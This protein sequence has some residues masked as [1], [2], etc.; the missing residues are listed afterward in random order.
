MASLPNQ[1]LRQ[2]CCVSNITLTL[3]DNKADIKRVT[4]NSSSERNHGYTKF[5]LR[6][7]GRIVFNTDILSAC[8]TI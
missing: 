3:Q 1:G 8:H 2:S 6:F 5:S 7:R 4:D